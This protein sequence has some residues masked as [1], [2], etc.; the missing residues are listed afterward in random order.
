MAER[1]GGDGAALRAERGRRRAR[2]PLLQA[3]F[4]AE[5]PPAMRVGGRHRVPH[6]P[7]ADAPR[8]GDGEAAREL[9]GRARRRE[10]SSS[11]G[12]RCAR[13]KA[14]GMEIGSHTMT[15]PVLTDLERATRS[16]ASSSASKNVIAEHVGEPPELFCYPHGNF[17][18]TRQEPSPPATTAPPSPASPAR[19]PP[20]PIRWSCGASPPTTSTSSPS[21]WR[22]RADAHDRPCRPLP[23]RAR[24]PRWSSRGWPPRRSPSP[25]RSRSPARFAPADYGTYKQLILLSQTLYYLLPLGMTQSLYYFVPRTRTPRPYLVQT[26]ELARGSRRARRRSRCR[27]SRGPLAQRLRQPRALAAPAAGWASTPSALLGAMP[28]EV[29]LT[30]QGRTRAAAA[31][32]LVSDAAKA[33][34]MTVPALARLRARGRGDGHGRLR[35][36]RGWPRPGPL[37]A[38]RRGAR[39]D[40]RGAAR[41]AALRPALRARGR[42]GR[43]A[44]VL[45]PVR[46][47]RRARRRRTFAIYAVGIFQVPLFDL[48][49]APTSE[50]LMVRI[51]ELEQA[52]RPERRGGELPGGGVEARRLLPARVRLPRRRGAG[53]HHRALHRPLHGLRQ[54][55]P[56]H[57]D[58]RR[59]GLPARRRSAPGAGLDAAHPLWPTPRRPAPTVPLVLWGVHAFGMLGAAGSWL[60]AEILGKALLLARVPAALGVPAEGRDALAR[61]RADGVAGPR[62]ARGVRRGEGRRARREAALRRARHRGDG[63]RGRLRRHRVGARRDGSR[64]CR[65]RRGPRRSRRRLRDRAGRWIDAP[66][67]GWA[68]P[69]CRFRLLPTPREACRDRDFRSRRGPCRGSPSPDGL[70][71]RSFRTPRVFE[72]RRVERVVSSRFPSSAAALK[73]SAAYSGSSRRFSEAFGIGLCALGH[74]LGLLVA[75]PVSFRHCDVGPLA[76]LVAA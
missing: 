9:R 7:G 52:G 6:P 65:G 63:L 59:P 26:L 75:R 56:H 46:R 67:L 61:N 25:S 28:L 22:G 34:A 17:S 45:P 55:L 1:A 14:G 39:H 51:A 37:H 49:Y 13:C 74:D 33:A 27:S 29:A 2:D 43:A 35:P 72:L 24:E 54:D 48:L 68:E 8:G 70:A 50:M 5:L 38:P 31:G 12:T 20:R 41:P 3:L 16:S 15:H 58:G 73:Y 4:E 19:T 10:R 44:A 66:D 64:S 32:Y 62:R 53:L 40:A 47:L 69:H 42:G 71:A 30:A 76:R 21:S 23:A 57:G 18:E 36:G 60:A 11:P